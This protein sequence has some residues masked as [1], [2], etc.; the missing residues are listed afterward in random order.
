MPRRRADPQQTPLPGVAAPVRP[1]RGRPRKRPS[2]GPHTFAVRLPQAL[3][4]EVD[5]RA[6]A[7]GLSY[8]EWLRE[9]IAAKLEEPP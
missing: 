2:R 9:A 3:A 6:Q 5:R 8:S 1:R 4:E 7:A